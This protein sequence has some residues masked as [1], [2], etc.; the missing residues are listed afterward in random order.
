[1]YLVTST[2]KPPLLTPTLPGTRI[3]RC[4]GDE[5]I[6]VELDWGTEDM[7]EPP[8]L[9]AIYAQVGWDGTGGIQRAAGG[10]SGAHRLLHGG[11]G[12]GGREGGGGGWIPGDGIHEHLHVWGGQAP[13][14]LARQYATTRV[15]DRGVGM[16]RARPNAL[17]LVGVGV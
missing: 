10:R 7:F 9:A 8:D 11:A 16:V 13:P 5:E 3:L 14:G 15:G 1:M 4:R 17:F 6:P 12:A 2:L